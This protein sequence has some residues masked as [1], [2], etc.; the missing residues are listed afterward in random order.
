VSDDEGQNPSRQYWKA[1]I[2]CL[3]TAEKRDAA[4]E[5]Y[6]EKLA[7]GGAG[8]TLSGLILLL[9][10][11]G[12]FLLT[13]PEKFH[14]GLT[15][16]ITEQLSALREELRNNVERQ[17]TS[18]R[19]AD[20]ANE[21]LEKANQLLAGASAELANKVQAAVRQID[22]IALA[23][24]VHVQLEASTVAP[25]RFALRDLPEQSRK[26]T[27]ASNAAASSVQTWRQVHLGGIILNV[28]LAALLVGILLFVCGWFWLQRHF[29][30]RLAVEIARLT[31]G[32]EA[33]KEAA[34]LDVPVHLMPSSDQNGNPIPGGYAFV[35]DQADDAAMQPKDGQKRGVIFF[36]AQRPIDQI[37]DLRGLLDDLQKSKER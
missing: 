27:A 9:E 29:N 22:V 37:N 5:F 8:E 1:A 12:V 17:R 34:L 15:Q 31:E 26:I 20:V 21:S 18:L 25:L 32:S 36:K 6:L 13:L 11:N 10:A 14:G 19:A 4:W 3:P 23:K 24:Q 30:E 2:S 28:S 35:I 7:G 16:P 33:F